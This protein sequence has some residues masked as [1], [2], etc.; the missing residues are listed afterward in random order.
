[1]KDRGTWHAAVQGI[2]KSWT[3]QQNSP[4]WLDQFTFPPTMQEGSLFS[5]PLL[6][7]LFIVFFFN[8]DHFDLGEM[9]PHWGLICI[10]LI[11]SHVERLFMC[12]LLIC[13][14]CDWF[15]IKRLVNPGGTLASIFPKRCYLSRVKSFTGISEVLDIK[16]WTI[17]RAWICKALIVW[18]KMASFRNQ[19]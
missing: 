17:Q 19:K 16:Y 14:P 10:S 2:T 12:L 3:E 8:D 7:S 15:L 18:S 9:V 1:M 4:Q 13:M 5:H 6:H 11:S